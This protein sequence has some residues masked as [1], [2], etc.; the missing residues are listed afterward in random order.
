[1]ELSAGKL[2]GMRRL[3]TPSGRFAM[4]AADQRPPIFDLVKTKR[5]GTVEPDD[6]CAVKAAIVRNLAPH[7]SAVLLDPIYAYSTCISHLPAHKG[8][9][10]TLEDHAFQATPGGRLSH[11]I[12]DW[13]VAK[14]KRLGAD[15]VKVLAWYR[16]DADPEVCRQQQDFVA[17]IGRAC[18]EHDICFLLELLV[19]PLPGDAAATTDYVEHAAKNPQRVIDSVAVFADP[20]FG[21]D[22]FKLESPL[23]AATLPDPET[24]AKFEVTA[25]QRWFDAL[26]AATNGRPWVMLSAGAQMDQFRRVLLYAYR[27]GASGYLAGRA[28]WWD[29]CGQFPDMKAVDRALQADGVP[30]MAA[31][32]RLTEES[33]LP[34]MKARAFSGGVKLAG[35]D[36]RFPWA[37]APA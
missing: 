16:T 14:I 18:V 33:A 27:A 6:V 34:W 37:Y 10:L 4:V 17:R 26:G 30:Y 9:L 29:A 21:V 19:Y 28:I 36:G 1:M 32:N 23:P 22:L 24:G 5:S 15:G 25:A 7:A 20:R 2:W 3:A 11:E 12:A 35:A 13:S 31:I 8:L